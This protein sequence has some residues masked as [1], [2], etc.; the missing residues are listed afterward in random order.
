[1]CYSI[2]QLT[3]NCVHD[4]YYFGVE[5][6]ICLLCNDVSHWLGA[7]LKSALLRYDWYSYVKILND[8]KQ[9]FQYSVGRMPC[10]GHLKSLTTVFDNW[11]YNIV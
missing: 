8:I 10:I 6:D 3:F 5:F 1:M 11:N 7:N 4:V 2:V 9:I